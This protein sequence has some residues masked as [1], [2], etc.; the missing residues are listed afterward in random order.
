MNLPIDPFSGRLSTVGN[1]RAGMFRTSGRLAGKAG[2]VATLVAYS[3]FL[4]LAAGYRHDGVGT[5]APTV[6]ADAARIKFGLV[7]VVLGY[8][9]IGLVL[10]AVRRRGITRAGRPAADPPSA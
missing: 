9:G 5:L 8:L 2:I 1:G 4:A 10:L 3:L 7:L 6:A